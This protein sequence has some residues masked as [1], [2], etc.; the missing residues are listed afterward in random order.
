MSV[1][2]TSESEIEIKLKGKSFQIAKETAHK[3]FP[4]EM[5]I[6]IFSWQLEKCFTRRHKTNQPN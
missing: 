5:K 3:Q 1:H 2:D 4:V 6:D